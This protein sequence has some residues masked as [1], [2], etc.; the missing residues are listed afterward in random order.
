[1][2]QVEKRSNKGFTLTEMLV[3]MLIVVMAST[4][5]ATGVPTAIEA[6]K[7]TVSSANAQVALTTTTS[8]LRAELGLATEVRVKNGAIYYVGDE[9]CW[10][11]IANS[12]PNDFGRGLTKTYC[13]GDFSSTGEPPEDDPTTY[14]LVPRA[15]VTDDLHVEFALPG[16]QEVSNALTL[17][18]VKVRDRDGN[19]LASVGG[20]DYQYRILT[21]FADVGGD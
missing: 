3:T 18:E 12:G 6:Y 8:A 2:N 14:D 16:K 5:L 15:S 21:R 9:G 20:T 1:M 13:K 19:P 4:L 11:K 17:Q 7:K 10:V